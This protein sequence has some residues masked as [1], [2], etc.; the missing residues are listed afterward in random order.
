MSGRRS[1]LSTPVCSSTS[2]TRLIGM[3]SH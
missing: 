3:I 2:S 1:L